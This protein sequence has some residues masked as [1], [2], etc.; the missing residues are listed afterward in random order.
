MNFDSASSSFRMPGLL[1]AALYN[2]LFAPASS[3]TPASVNPT[4]RPGPPGIKYLR[5]V[6]WIS[7]TDTHHGGEQTGNYP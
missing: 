1:L 6:T 5:Q 3:S 7:S 2:S 4:Y